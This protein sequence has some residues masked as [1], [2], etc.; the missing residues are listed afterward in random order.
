MIDMKR[1]SSSIPDRTLLLLEA[2]AA[3][4]GCSL[5]AIIAYLLKRECE[6]AEASGLIELQE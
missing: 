4:E 5:S 1:I 3:R 2:W 6:S